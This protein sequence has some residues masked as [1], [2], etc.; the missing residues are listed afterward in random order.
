MPRQQSHF[1]EL[2]LTQE[3]HHSLVRSLTEAN[4]TGISGEPVRFDPVSQEYGMSVVV[5]PAGA[6]AG[7]WHQD[8]VL[9]L[10]FT[11]LC[12]LESMDA[13]DCRTRFDPAS[14]T[15]RLDHNLWT[16]GEVARFPQNTR[17]RS[18][19]NLTKHPQHLLCLSLWQ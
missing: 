7:E 6:K 17:Q 14:V 16:R 2:S 18:P 10:S 5:R 3:K 19:A 4:V 13:E 1:H 9:P 15:P 11:Y 12:P 8:G